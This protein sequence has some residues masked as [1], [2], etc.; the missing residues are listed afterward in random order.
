MFCSSEN[1]SPRIFGVTLLYGYKPNIIHLLDELPLQPDRMAVA[2]RQG[3]LGNP[4][5]TRLVDPT[6]YYYH[7]LS[8]LAKPTKTSLHR[9]TTRIIIAAIEVLQNIN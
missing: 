5:V 9:V 1:S 8:H 4:I 7:S 6:R 3:H 2:T